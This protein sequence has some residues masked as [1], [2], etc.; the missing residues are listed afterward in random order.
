V[1][2]AT[3]GGTFIEAIKATI[4][5]K[6]KAMT[7]ASVE[8]VAGGPRDH[9]SK[10]AAAGGRNV[11]FDVVDL[12]A[13]SQQECIRQGLFDAVQPSE[14]GNANK[15]QP[16]AWINKGYAPAREWIVSGV[17][18]IEER[19]NANGLSPTGFEILKD[20]K[21]AG[22]VAIPE[23]TNPVA[24]AFL[25]G[26]AKHLSGDETNIDAAL[27]FLEQ[28]KDPIFFP[29]F[30]ALQ[31][32]FNSGEIWMVPGN[33]AY[34]SRLKA[35]NST[36]A[37]M[38]PAIRDRHAIGYAEGADIVKGSPRRKLALAWL[39]AGLDT[40]VQIAMAR[41]AG[42]SPTNVEAAAVLGKDPQ[43]ASRFLTTKEDIA[44]MYFPDWAKINT[45]YP[46]WVQRWNRALR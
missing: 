27:T 26:L 39:D 14:L 1:R 22:H 30:A 37:F 4:E 15:L 12:P 43:F 5:P 18:Y 19:L 11:P 9:M 16:E 42:Y 13:D 41:L 28:I 29:N 44:G 45:A 17:L 6:F 34:L 32:R 25:G 46:D 24:P 21:L 33:L 23:I 38:R 7:G 8:Y 3:F 36:V 20:P 35:P 10:M 2:V 31:T 40:E